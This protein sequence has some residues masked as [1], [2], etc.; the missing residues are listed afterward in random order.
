MLF[1]DFPEFGRTVKA[2]LK[3]NGR[4]FFPVYLYFPP[5]SQISRDYTQIVTGRIKFPKDDVPDNC[6]IIVTF[7]L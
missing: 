1:G 5:Y 6:K 7:I 3:C 4:E 2:K